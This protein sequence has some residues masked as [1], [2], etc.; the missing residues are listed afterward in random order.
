[1]NNIFYMIFKK[2]NNNSEL[3]NIL[4]TY[5]KILFQFSADW[6]APCKRIT[7]EVKKYAQSI[8]NDSLCYCYIDV[9]KLEEFSNSREIVSI[10]TF[11]VYE[12]QSNSFIDKITSSDIEVIKQFCEKNSLN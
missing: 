10:P 6:C 7:P 3:N 11:M 12:K 5:D 2:P 4:E 8:E 1:M 9:D